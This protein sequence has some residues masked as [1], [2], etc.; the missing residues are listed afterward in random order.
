[1][2]PSRLYE[3]LRK[4]TLP[5]QIDGIL[6]RAGLPSDWIAPSPA[7]VAQRA[8][9]IVVVAQQGGP[10][11]LARIADALAKE[12]PWVMAPPPA[13]PFRAA[14]LEPVYESP[15]VRALAEQLE[16]ARRRRQAL[17]AA[18]ASTAEVD[19]QILDLRRKL[20]EGGRLRAGDALGDGRY[21][22][23]ELLGRGGFASVFRALDRE[24]G[25]EVAIKVMHA[26][27][28]GDPTR[29]ERFFRGARVMATLDHAAVVR[30]LEPGAEDG[31]HFYFVMALASGG[32]LHRAV[33][34]GRVRP[35]AALPL[36]LQVGDALAEAHARGIVH[37]DVKPANILLDGTGAPL[38]TDFDLVALGNTTG[39]T[40]TGAAMGS[41]L[42]MA[43]EQAHDAKEADARA[44]VYGLGMTALFCLHGRELP[45]IVQRRPEQVIAKLPVDAAIKAALT[46]AIEIEPEARFAD[47]RGFCEA[48][49]AAVRPAPA[50][51]VGEATIETASTWREPTLGMSLV[52]APP[53]RF[54]MGSSK[55][56]GAPG[57][58]EEAYD[59]ELP[60][61]E[62]ELPHGVW[63][64]EHPVTNAEYARFFAETKR[65]EPACWQDARFNAP[66]QPVVGV[67]FE[68][69]LAFCAWLTAHAGL[70]G[71]HM[72]DLPTEAE[73]EHAARGSDGRRYPWGS[74]APTPER[75]C[76]DL[77]GDTGAPATVGGRPAGKSPFGCQDMAGNVWEW[78]LDA[79]RD[80]YGEDA[81]LV[82]N[83]CHP[84]LRGAPR[85]VRGGSWLDGA[86]FLRCAVR[87]GIDPGH[88]IADLGF[89][90]VC[91]GSRQ[92]WLVGS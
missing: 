3:L 6:L 26:E 18:K 79:W 54:L 75:A 80:S 70:Q 38:L 87:L 86:R 49:R 83:P 7:S 36:V 73:W 43:P 8:H 9:D 69:S 48:L 41:F 74:E 84:G 21:L 62:V 66:A 23:L 72:F 1:M 59:D 65:A 50:A 89:R 57:F 92:P 64:G 4:L 25:E 63:I 71:G 52:W 68:D 30:V 91:R 78:C 33:V 76:F 13:A 35:E 53:A 14:P 37:R 2:E 20:R 61:H 90:V 34:K 17:H 32:D 82:V 55:Q 10:V 44:D 46:Q 29:R 77:R 28:A 47:A 16:D 88:R 15:E 40:R 27:Q 31:S 60:A 45:A 85:V 51:A 24:R 19:V 81:A 42:F 22:L 39:G 12:A 5:A 58:D 11:M 67:S 56:R